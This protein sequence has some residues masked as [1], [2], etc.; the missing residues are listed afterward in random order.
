ME[1]EQQIVYD[2]LMPIWESVSADYKRKY[3]KNIWAQFEGMLKSASACN[4]LPAF[5][6]KLCRRV[7]I[8]PNKENGKKI[9][10]Y[11]GRNN[12]IDTE[13]LT[14]IR[15]QT[16]YLTLVLRSL[17]EARKEESKNKLADQKSLF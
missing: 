17:N 6:Q 12:G 9:T 16:S 4:T 11:I 13:T 8:N 15:K 5:Y 2:F 14:I 3:V 1:K 10:D 7:D